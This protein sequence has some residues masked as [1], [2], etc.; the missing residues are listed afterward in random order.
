M[1]FCFI[2][3]WT[4]SQNNIVSLWNHDSTA[5]AHTQTQPNPFFTVKM[6]SRR[7]EA[8]FHQVL[9]P[10]APTRLDGTAGNLE[11]VQTNIIELNK[12]KLQQEMKTG[13]IPSE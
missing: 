6:W 11:K 5:R 12:D 1:F 4:N 2:D 3:C 13:N 8:S 10:A 9:S 7:Q